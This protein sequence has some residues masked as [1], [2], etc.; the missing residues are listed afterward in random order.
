MPSIAQDDTKWG[1]VGFWLMATDHPME[2]NKSTSASRYVGGE[3]FLQAY[4]VVLWNDR[5]QVHFQRTD[6]I[7]VP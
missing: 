3:D 2:R 4:D 5:L 6:T 7:V 1:K